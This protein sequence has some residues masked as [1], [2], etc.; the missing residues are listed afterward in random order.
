MS[1]DI[2][3]SIIV[4]FIQKLK[5]KVVRNNINKPQFRRIVFTL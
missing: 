3:D 1:K 2:I 4:D 5:T